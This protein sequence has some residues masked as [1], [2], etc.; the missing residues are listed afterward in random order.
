MNTTHQSSASPPPT[1]RCQSGHSSMRSLKQPTTT[2]K[3]PGIFERAR[4]RRRRVWLTVLLRFLPWLGIGALLVATACTVMMIYIPKWSNGEAVD[5]WGIRPS[6]YV[7]VA[8][9]VADH[10]IVYAFAKGLILSWLRKK[11]NQRGPL[12]DLHHL[13]DHDVSA[14][15]IFF[16]GRFFTAVAAF[17]VFITPMNAPLLQRSLTT[18]ST[19]RTSSISGAIPLASQVPN[20]LGRTLIPEGSIKWPSSNVDVVWDS[21][22]NGAAVKV[23]NDDCEEECHGMVAGAGLHPNCT[24]TALDVSEDSYT[25]ADMFQVSV[26]VVQS[27]SGTSLVNLT[28]SYKGDSGCSAGLIQ[29]TC[30]MELATVNYSVIFQNH[31]LLLDPNSTIEDDKLIGPFITPPGGSPIGDILH[32]L[33]VPIALWFSPTTTTGENGTGSLSSLAFRYMTQINFNDTSDSGC[34]AS[35]RDPM[36]D[37]LNMTRTMMFLTSYEA[38]FD[39]TPPTMQDVEWKIEENFNAFET[40]HW[41]LFFAIVVTGL[42]IIAA[43]FPYYHYWRR[44]HKVSLS[45]EEIAIT[46]NAAIENSDEATDGEYND[47]KEPGAVQIREAKV[48]D[49]DD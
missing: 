11:L 1:M 20:N 17:L 21:L 44:G 14:K 49:H 16:S 46:F 27:S 43:A 36:P 32:S 2:P 33:V 30:M 3:S 10:L 8:S 5:S 45:P 6:V 19:S 41:W 42:G 13:W 26:N 39:S 25:S 35:F 23:T 4:H 9:T 31:A 24:E 34:S 7:S 29:H 38:A 22:S 15:A 37:M 12:L 18:S 48:V 47:A 40:H 28:A